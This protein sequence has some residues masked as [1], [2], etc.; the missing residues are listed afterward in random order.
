MSSFSKA[1]LEE[2]RQK[3]NL[4]EV[5]SPHVNLKSQGAFYK[6]L[7][8]FHGEKT[9][10]FVLHK[11]ENHYHCYG[12]GAHGDAISFLMNYLKMSFLDAVEHLADHFH[13]HL[14]KS[15][16][17]A[18]PQTDKSH[19]KSAMEKAC[20]FF[21]FCLLHSEEGKQALDYLYERGMDLN[22]IQTFRIGFAP[23]RRALFQKYMEKNKVNNQTL[24]ECGLLTEKK[25]PFFYDRITI[26]ILDAMGAVTA[27]SARKYKPNTFGGK[28]IN[29]PETVLFKKSKTLFG[30]SFARK[31]IVKD[32]WAL[33][34]EGQF[35]ALRLIYAG[36]TATIASQGTAFGKDHVDLL[37][38]LGIQNVYIA[39][40][41]DKAG[42]EAAIKA[43]DLFQ[44]EGIEVKVLS[45]EDDLDPDNFIL[46][47]GAKEFESAIE[48]AVDYL[49]F[50]V[51]VKSKEINLQSPAHKTRLIED[52]AEQIR[53]WDHP[54]MVH[55]SLRKLS[56]LTQTPLELMSPSSTTS[57]VLLKKRA[58]VSHTD[59]DADLILEADLLR[60]LYLLGDTYP[61]FIELSKLNLTKEHFKVNVCKNLFQTYIDACASKK[62]KDLLSLTI[63]LKGAEE[64]LFL[65]QMLQKRID[66]S[67]ADKFFV[68]TVQKLLDRHWMSQ[69]ETIK[70]KILSGKL[71]DEE[72]ME[73][74]KQFDCI[75]KQRPVVKFLKHDDTSI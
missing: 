66:E 10:S 42:V 30:L 69:R 22:F 50:L 65:G 1:S 39:F 71:N 16:T 68:D 47:K 61:D 7:C 3:I 73:L 44:K 43:G 4:V 2:L 70:E 18:A 35:D 67:K 60:W 59:I 52:I 46:E 63:A 32:K 74:A 41:S 72:A 29:S 8:P 62:P 24:K 55:E 19:L 31:K 48:K 34:V 11:G 13:V 33:I 20:N 40:D 51:Q 12:C 23:N 54:L 64:Q 45:L 9:P 38:N 58:S 15:E 27:F 14:E 25:Y 36:F 26:P 56:R 5:L 17:F 6:G 53:N 49:S 75:K 28:Y 37:L 21:Q 57:E